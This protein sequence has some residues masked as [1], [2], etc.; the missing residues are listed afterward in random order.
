MRRVYLFI[1]TIIAIGLI[2][3]FVNPVASVFVLKCPLKFLTGWDCP[4]CGTQRF[5][6]AL[7]NGQIYEAFSYNWFLIPVLPYI[8]LIVLEWLLP[9]G[10]SLKAWLKAKVGNRWVAMGYLTAYFIWGVVRNIIGV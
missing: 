9:Y 6:H 8:S 3:Y 7:L 10:N 4:S 2:Y 5:L 1:A